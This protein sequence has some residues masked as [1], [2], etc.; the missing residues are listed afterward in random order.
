MIKDRQIVSALQESVM[1]CVHFEIVCS[2][3]GF[4]SSYVPKKSWA[5]HL[6]DQDLDELL[7]NSGT[8]NSSRGKKLPHLAANGTLMLNVDSPISENLYKDF[9]SRILDSPSTTPIGLV[10]TKLDANLSAA[11]TAEKILIKHFALLN[12]HVTRNVALEDVLG[13]LFYNNADSLEYV[14]AFT[15]IPLNSLQKCSNLRVL[16][17]TFSHSSG[18]V[19]AAQLFLALQHLHSLEYFEWSQSL[20]I[21]TKDLLALHNLLSNHLPKLLHWHWNF[22]YLL[23]FI[24][25]LDNLVFEPL[26]TL[27]KTLLAGKRATPW[28]ETYKFSS[29]NHHIKY[30]LGTIR[31]HVCFLATGATKKSINYPF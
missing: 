6:F 17:L 9:F 1:N 28:C 14:H 7:I 21:I 8:V 30:W 31:P 19:G 12:H 16:S 26:E 2:G 24:S 27:L 18:S 25:D 22:C 4:L 29:E 5:L 23:L 20:N 11:L 10:A 13:K 3:M 15:S